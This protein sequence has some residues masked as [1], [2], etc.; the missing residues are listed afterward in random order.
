MMFQADLLRESVDLITAF[1]IITVS[2]LVLGSIL[3]LLGNAVLNDSLMNRT[4]SVQF[5]DSVWS[6]MLTRHR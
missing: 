3:M 5:T 1:P 2:L 6:Q 4:E